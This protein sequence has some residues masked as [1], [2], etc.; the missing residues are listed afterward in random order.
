MQVKRPGSGVDVLAVDV[1]TGKEAWRVAVARPGTDSSTTRCTTRCVQPAAPR[2]A[3]DADTRPVVACVVADE[4]T[5]IES[6][7]EQFPVTTKSRLVILDASTGVVLSDRTTDPTTGVSALGADLIIG[8]VD[9]A[10]HVQVT[11]RTTDRS[12]T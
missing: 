10:G 7:A 8:R 5:V 6:P 11:R 3:G 1:V 12:P 9:A 4:T 2:V